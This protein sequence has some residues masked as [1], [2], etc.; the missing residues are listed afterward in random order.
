MTTGEIVT[1]IAA[2]A[3]WT[4]VLTL[5][6]LIIGIAVGAVLC[7]MRTSRSVLL[8]SVAALLILTFRAVPPIVWLFLIFFGVGA[9]LIQV[10]PFEAAAIGL[11][12]ITG[13]NLGEIFRGS[14]AAIHHG[15]WEAARAL[16]LP[17]SSRF[18][19]VIGPQLLRVAL[20]SV[21]TYSIGLLKDTAIASVIGV[22]EIT[23][24]AS[25]VSQ[26]T[27][28]GLEVFAVAGVLYILLSMPIAWLTRR[29]DRRLR[30]RVA[31]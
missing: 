28:I 8:G 26:R 9:E 22:P 31:R 3:V 12:L 17:R 4:L 5:V 29:V 19:D 16:S 11:G 27:F 10:N 14:L 15:Q 21:A 25:H 13:A 1:T 6:S 23:F 18:L 2:G 24:Q 30:M 20:P 7:A